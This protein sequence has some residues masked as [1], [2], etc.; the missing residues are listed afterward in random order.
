M[1]FF[2]FPHTFLRIPSANAIR[3]LRHASPQVLPDGNHDCLG[4]ALSPPGTDAKDNPGTVA[5]SAGI[6]LTPLVLTLFG[7]D[8]P[9]LS[10]MRCARKSNGSEPTRRIELKPTFYASFGTYR[11][12]DYRPFLRT[13]A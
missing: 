6:A 1:T 4:Q 2:Q 9:T 3:I 5:I 11:K 10:N 13:P 8:G 7:P 12:M